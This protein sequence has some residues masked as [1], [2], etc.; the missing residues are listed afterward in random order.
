MPKLS[1][2]SH[3]EFIGR[4]RL[5]G[6]H[7]PYAGGKHLFMVKDDLRL[8]IPNPHRKEIEVSLLIR[9]GVPVIP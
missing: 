8:T 3:N 2:V 6:F 1:P 4:L 9:Y 7:G 5:F